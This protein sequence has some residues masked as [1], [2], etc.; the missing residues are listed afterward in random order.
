MCEYYGI[1][2]V[3]TEESYTS[4]SSFLD[5]DF[6]PTFGAKPEGWNKSGKRVKRG[7]YRTGTGKL[8]NADLNGAANILKKVETQLGLSRSLGL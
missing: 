8:I 1:K 5:G 6:L 7:M 4:K 3:E 2:F